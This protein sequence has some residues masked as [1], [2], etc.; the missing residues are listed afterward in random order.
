MLL[1]YTLYSG[2]H[3]NLKMRPVFPGR[4]FGHQVKLCDAETDPTRLEGLREKTIFNCPWNE[5]TKACRR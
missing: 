4:S 5:A 2:L 1:P 3:M